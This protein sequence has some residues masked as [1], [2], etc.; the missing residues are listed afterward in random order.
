MVIFK[1]QN[2]ILTAAAAST[3]LTSPLPLGLW[4][5]CEAS[6]PGGLQLKR[7]QFKE[8]EK[9]LPSVRVSE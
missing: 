2:K 5:L 8:V 4:G 6:P 1:A 7:L 9:T 3:V